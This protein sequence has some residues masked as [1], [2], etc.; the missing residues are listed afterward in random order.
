MQDIIPQDH[1]NLIHADAAGLWIRK[2][3]GTIH[4]RTAKLIADQRSDQNTYRKRR[5]ARLGGST[6]DA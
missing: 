3:F 4:P 6:W 5:P 2:K 1:L